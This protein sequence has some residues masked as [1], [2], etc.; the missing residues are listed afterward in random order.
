MIKKYKNSF[1]TSYALGTTLVFEL[2]QNRSVKTTKIYIH[3]S[4]NKDETYN[5][6]ISL[7]H[8]L[9]IQHE[10][11]IKPFNILSSK[12]N[13]YVIGEFEKFERLLVEG[14]HI[15]LVNPMDAGNIGTIM[16]SALGFGF[17]SIAIIKPAVDIFNPKVIRSSMGSIFSLNIE[18]FD[19]FDEYRLRFPNN[20]IFPFLLQAKTSLTNVVV[21]KKN[22]SLVFGNEASGLPR[23]FLNIGTPLIIKHSNKID[24]LNLPIALSIALYEFT[25]KDF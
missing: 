18:Y 13:C 16:R 8:T 2:L 15:V 1:Q 12:E 17:K 24:S 9:G 20:S 14:N 25:K 11:S 6:L 7:C 10:E 3:P 19:S 5:K 23:E 21:P 4:L 22:Y